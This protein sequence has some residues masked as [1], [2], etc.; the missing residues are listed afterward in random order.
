MKH[1]NDNEGLKPKIKEEIEDYFKYRWTRHRTLPIE[2][3]EG[4]GF[5]G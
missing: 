2:S 5:S 1:F 4:I 3:D